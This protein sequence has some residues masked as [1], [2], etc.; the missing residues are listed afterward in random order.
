MNYSKTKEDI[1][2]N[3]NGNNMDGLY[4]RCS[5]CQKFFKR[6]DLGYCCLC[7]TWWGICLICVSKGESQCIRHPN[8]KLKPQD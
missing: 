6:N 2:I 4:F 1:D 8:I 7:K 5:I 3:N